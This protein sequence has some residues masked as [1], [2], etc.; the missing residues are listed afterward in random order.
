MNLKRL[1]EKAVGEGLTAAGFEQA[2]PVIKQAARPEFGDYQANGVIAAA[3]KAGR[4]P[5]EI[6]GTVAAALPRGVL[7]EPEVAGPGFINLRLEG[8][9]LDARMNERYRNGEQVEGV[10]T[11]RI[12]VDYSSPN[13]AKEM[14]VGHL[15]PTVIGDAL[16][17][18]LE[19]LG[20]DVIRVNH[21]GDWGAQFGSLL[22]FLDEMP[23]INRSTSLKDLEAF[24]REASARFRSDEAFATKARRFVVRLQSGDPNCLALWKQFIAESIGHCEAVYELFNI[25]LKTEHIRAE[26]AYNDDLQKIVR[27]LEQKG[28]ITVSDGA[29]C[30]FLPGFTGK[31]D[32]PLP[33][34]VQKSDGGYPYLATDLAALRYRAGELYVDRALY[35]VGAPQ[36]LHLKQ[37]FALGDAAG[38]LD[39]QDFRHVPFGSIL[40][41][42]GK[43]FKTRDGADVKL[44]NVLN[45]AVARAHEVVTAKNPELSAKER[46]RVARVVGIGAVK[47]A[48]LSKNR[49]TDYIFDWDAMLSFEGNTAPYLQYAYTRIRSIFRRAGIDAD[50]LEGAVRLTGAAE[51]AL[52]LKLLQF[53]ETVEQ[54]IHDNQPNVLCNY[55]YELSGTFMS[56]YEACPV[57]N[58][59]DD[60]RTSR[61]IVCATAARTLELGLSLLGIET[62][63]QM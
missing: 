52:A 11:S 49:M 2:P 22:A 27:D 63:E 41:D 44:I 32:K 15:R 20:N 10:E 34:M 50:A 21:V 23:V 33:A 59:P 19:F 57:L 46:D 17:R 29:K 47:Y 36:T 58:A 53:Q 40:K 12:A 6:A 51:R 35:V 28:L 24:Y 30:V 16:V 38:Y 18:V 8:G 14:H 25:T 13:L 45:E 56:F 62:V 48:E 43:P 31:D 3:K 61:L 5:R 39:D 7:T 4:N 42:D 54:V 9:W 37:L 55:L 60:V 26:S 1:I